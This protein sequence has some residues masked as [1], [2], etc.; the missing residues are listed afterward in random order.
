MSLKLVQCLCPERHL[1][2]A[3]LFRE[4]VTVEQSLTCINTIISA[5]IDGN[6]PDLLALVGLPGS[7][8]PHCRLCRASRE[9]WSFEIGAMAESDPRK[10]IAQLR[11]ENAQQHHHC[12]G[13]N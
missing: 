9:T 5:A 10:A 4:A 11:Q 2:L 1:I 3:V 12:G 7:L 8:R 6:N 13:W